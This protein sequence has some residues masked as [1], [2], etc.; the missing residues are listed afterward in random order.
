MQELLRDL[1][2]G[3]AQEIIIELLYLG[4]VHGDTFLFEAVL[5][6]EGFHPAVLIGIAD[7]A[8]F[9]SGRY[10][11]LAAAVDAAAGTSHDLDERILGP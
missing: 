1:T 7:P 4:V 6:I 8:V 3:L 2:S 5:I 10:D 9:L 11:G